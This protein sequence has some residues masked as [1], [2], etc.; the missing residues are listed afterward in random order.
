ML[1]TYLDGTRVGQ[2]TNATVN[3]AQIVNQTVRDSNRLFIGRSQDDTAPAIHARLRDV[4]IYRVALTDQQVATIRNNALAARPAT[5]TRA[6]APEISTAAI[7]LDSPLASTIASVPDITV[8]TV[9]GTL[10]RLP[11]EVAVNYRDNRRGPSVRVIW[12]S[13]IDNSDVLKPGTYTVTGKLP[14]TNFAPKATVIVKVPVGTTTPPSRLAEPFALSD[15]LLERDTKGATRRSSGTGT[16]SCAAWRPAIPTTSSTTSGTRSVSRSR[17]GATQLEGWDNQTT[18]LR[19]HAS[20]HYLSA[21]AQ[22]Y[23]SATYDAA[24]ACEL[25]SEDELPDRHA[26]RPVAEVGA[27]GDGRRARGG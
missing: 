18:R 6:P 12:P 23:A 4:R 9:V 24:L 15:V 21:I 27:A 19:G 14:G 20:G 22:A 8:E 1:T 26:V 10:P 5:V 3:G 13:P 16:S 7:P 11:I 25:P 2:A 17:A